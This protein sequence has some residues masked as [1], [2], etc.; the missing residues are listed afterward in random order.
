MYVIIVSLNKQQ[1]K[2]H[3]KKEVLNLLSLTGARCDLDMEKMTT[4]MNHYKLQ[5][6]LWWFRL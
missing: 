5:G 1:K 2:G 3:L 6:I 4:E